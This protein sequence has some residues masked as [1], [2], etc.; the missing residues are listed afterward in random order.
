[1]ENRQ[2]HKKRQFERGVM[3]EDKNRRLKPR[4]ACDEGSSIF[5]KII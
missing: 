5:M 3:K 1:M 4:S 2:L